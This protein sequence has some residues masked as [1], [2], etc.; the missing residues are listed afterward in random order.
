MAANAG[1][2]SAPPG[3]KLLQ[4]RG[5]GRDSGGREVKP[6]PGFRRLPPTKPAELSP[7]AALVWDELV[8]ELQRLQLLKPIDGL[9]LQMACEAYVRWREAS[10]QLAAEG[11]T[12]TS[13]TGLRKLNP[14]VGVVERA[15]SEFRAW[16]A[17]FG[18]T[19]AAESKLASPEGGPGEENPF[20]GSG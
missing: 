10:E 8:A 16:C 15:A 12:Y 19:P 18:M 11:M 7:G 20:A 14:L 2:K 3:L 17:E 4:G 9:A 13:D 5:P 1:R 6:T